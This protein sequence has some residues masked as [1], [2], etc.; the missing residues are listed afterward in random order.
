MREEL[1]LTR[2][3]EG[4]ADLEPLPLRVSLLKRSSRN[5]RF[6]GMVTTFLRSGDCVKVEWLLNFESR[7][8]VGCDLEDDGMVFELE[9]YRADS[10]KLAPRSEVEG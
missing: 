1:E 7:A 2:V 9:K 6:L 3:L 5:L 10:G 8:Y 4:E